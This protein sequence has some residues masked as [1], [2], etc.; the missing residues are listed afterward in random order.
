MEA[1]L[2]RA[3]Y[4]VMKEGA[5]ENVINPGT[6]NTAEIVIQRLRHKTAS[7]YRLCFSQD[8]NTKR[9]FCDSSALLMCRSDR[10]ASALFLP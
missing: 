7:R 6:T 1:L 10:K 9:M 5:V 4:S 8:P 2:I 3:I